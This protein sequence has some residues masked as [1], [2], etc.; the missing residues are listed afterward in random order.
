MLHNYTLRLF[1]VFLLPFF[2]FF[3]LSCK[4]HSKL[5][6]YSS[7]FFWDQPVF[8]SY[9]S[10]C[11]AQQHLLSPLGTIIYELSLVWKDCFDVESYYHKFI[12]RL[13]KGIVEVRKWVCV[14]L[15]LHF[16]Q[17]PAYTPI[18]MLNI[19]ILVISAY[20]FWMN[21]GWSVAVIHNL[22]T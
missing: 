13:L 18:L 9:V 20:L 21:D 12:M 19:C 16:L 22:T 3:W 4:I 7:S 17:A 1:L 6:Y 10:K 15:F 11:S 5:K 14:P 2:L 8:T